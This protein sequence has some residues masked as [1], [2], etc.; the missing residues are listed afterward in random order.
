ML[1]CNSRIVHIVVVVVARMNVVCPSFRAPNTLRRGRL[2]TRTRRYFLL[3]LNVFAHKR[4]LLLHERE[5]RTPGS[6]HVTHQNPIQITPD[7]QQAIAIQNTSYSARY[8]Q[9]GQDNKTN[10][11]IPHVPICFVPIHPFAQRAMLQQ[12]Q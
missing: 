12:R 11:H 6:R 1:Y 3:S 5:H 4:R 10:L 7:L 8:M 2:V 9:P